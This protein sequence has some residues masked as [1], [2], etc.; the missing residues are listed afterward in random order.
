MY[1]FYIHDV[2]LYIL[3]LKTT[4]FCLSKNAICIENLEI[5]VTKN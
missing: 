2:K 5:K 3:K 1:Y 4:Q